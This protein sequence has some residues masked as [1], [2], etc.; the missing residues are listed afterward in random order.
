MTL[1][2]RE[3]VQAFRKLVIPHGVPVIVQSSLA[4][5]QKLE[6][7][8]STLV[9]ALMS[10]F[11]TLLTPAFTY[12]TMV[13]PRSGPDNNGIEYGTLEEISYEAAFFEPDIPVHPGLGRV[14]EIIRQHM[15][16][17]RSSHPVLSF[18]GW[19]AEDLLETQT[20]ED[21]LAPLKALLE[22]KGWSI[23]LGLSPGE[24]YCV[25]LGEQLAGR[26]QFIRW[27]LT[28]L[29]VIECPNF[30]GCSDGF[31]D[32]TPVLK[33]HTHQVALSGETIYA[34]P[35]QKLVAVVEN[36]V[37]DNPTALLCSDP[38]CLRCQAVL[39][40]IDLD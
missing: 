13:V 16:S 29:G 12:Q 38:D 11:P 3:I 20:L 25:H 33:A 6:G 8:A 2:Y 32:L 37:R 30:P 24:D 5:F 28:P 15:R 14:P 10:V 27:A 22:R 17:K 18:A 26:K 34:V 23:M 1:N 39:N 31:P 21:P 36:L 7:G 40:E 35:L 4:P 19:G 9:G